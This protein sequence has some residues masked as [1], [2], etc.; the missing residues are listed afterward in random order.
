MIE[1]TKQN[2]TLTVID[3]SQ[4]TKIL[5]IN[6]IKLLKLLFLEINVN[7]LQTNSYSLDR[8]NE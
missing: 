2:V 8:I 4:I 7:P 3:V 5:N 6:Q 1:E